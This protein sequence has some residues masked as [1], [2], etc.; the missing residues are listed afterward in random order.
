[1]T[2]TATKTKPVR[3]K[4][5]RFASP[6]AKKRVG[7]PRKS[8]IIFQK[9]EKPPAKIKAKP[10]NPIGA[11]GYDDDAAELPSE[12]YTSKRV[13]RNIAQKQQMA[14]LFRINLILM[15]L[16]FFLLVFIYALLL[17]ALYDWRQL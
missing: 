8:L 3:D 10:F 12:P 4:S 14:I 9:G 11:F 7:R 15:M 13:E 5:G 1:M 16:A 17:T 6:A 2:K